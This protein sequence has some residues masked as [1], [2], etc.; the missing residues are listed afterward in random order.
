MKFSVKRDT[1]AVALSV[2]RAA[3]PAKSIQPLLDCVLLE[4]DD[5]ES[6][7]VS[8]TDQEVGIQ[9]RVAAV[10]E[11]SGAT[12]VPGR[13][14]HAIISNLPDESVVLELEGS[15][16][17]VTSGDCVFKLPCLDP[18]E[19]PAMPVSEE[20][21]AAFV[22]PVLAAA[23]E[24][25]QV[26][27]LRDDPQR[28]VICGVHFKP[29]GS[30][31]MLAATNSH[32]LACQ[33]IPSDM[34]ALSFT[35]PNKGIDAV[36]VALEGAA[37]DATC[38]IGLVPESGVFQARVGSTTVTSRLIEGEYADVATILGTNSTGVVVKAARD[39]LAAAIRRAMLVAPERS[40]GVKVEFGVS[41][42]GD[43]ANV[44]TIGALSED[45]G[46][47]TEQVIIDYSGKPLHMG[48]M[49]NYMLDALGAVGENCEIHVTEERA[50]IRFVDGTYTHLV[51]VM[52]L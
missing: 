16:L 21:G 41:K 12:A 51:M 46:Q 45:S 27:A 48:F 22:A 5:A 37:K 52:L 20:D 23:L 14:L 18:Q 24:R 29:D 47:S 7:A 49:G 25:V 39:K 30:A 19:F 9:Q 17:T 31:L 32:R 6:V 35:V 15:Q 38:T 42:N 2:A 33:T 1:F 8:A 28:A 10:V 40:K 26:A 4:A 3:L 34:M 13:R 11:E 36:K 43:E 50:P 44:A